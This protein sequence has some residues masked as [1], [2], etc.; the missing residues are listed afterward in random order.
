MFTEFVGEAPERLMSVPYFPEVD[1]FGN[2]LT[3]E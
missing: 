2:K 1:G 3:R